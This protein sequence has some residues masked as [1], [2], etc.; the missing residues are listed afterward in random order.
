MSKRKAR[1]FGFFC[2]FK[3]GEV[4]RRKRQRKKGESARFFFVVLIIPMGRALLCGTFRRAYKSAPKQGVSVSLAAR[5]KS[6][7]LRYQSGRPPRTALTGRARKKG[8]D[9][10]TKRAAFSII[11]AWRKTGKSVFC[12]EKKDKTGN[13]RA[14]RRKSSAPFPVNTGRLGGNQLSARRLRENGFLHCTAA[15]CRELSPFLAANGR[16]KDG[17]SR[18]NRENFYCR[19]QF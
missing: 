14:E 8:N 18:R 2:V 3:G 16:Q 1:F 9:L 6:G 11:N 12:R 5:R 7:C 4:L 15:L 19:R 17:R 13:L 10:L